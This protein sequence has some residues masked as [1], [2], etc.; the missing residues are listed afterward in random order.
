MPIVALA[1]MAVLAVAVLPSSLRPPPDQANAS[2]ELSPDAPPEDSPDA[3]ISSFT[4]A[5]SSTA[6]AGSDDAAPTTTLPPPEPERRASTGLCFGDPPRQTESV[7]APECKPEFVGDNGGATAK[8]VFPDQVN[9][10][11]WHGATVPENKGPVPTEPGSNEN[12][13]DRTLR[14]LQAYFNARYETYNRRIQLVFIDTPDTTDTGQQ[15]AAATAD[16]TYQVFASTHL[17]RAY[18]DELVRRGVICYSENP[19]PDRDLD[20]A[21]PYFWS[22]Q[23]SGTRN[24]RLVAEYLCKRLVGGTAD[25][26]AGSQQGA[27]RKFG[28]I[29]E[30]DTTGRSFEDF[31]RAF[32][33]ACGETA[34]GYDVND[35]SRSGEN[36]GQ[37]AVAIASLQSKGVTTIVNYMQVGSQLVAMQAADSAGYYPEWFITGSYGSDFNLLSKVQPKGQMSQAFGLSGIELPRPRPEMECTRAYKTIDPNNNPDDG[38]CDQYWELLSQVVGGIQEA[39]P[40]L[41]AETFRDGFYRYGRRYPPERWAFHGGYAPG[42]HSFIDKMGEIWW[43]PDAFERGSRV[44]G[45]FTWT[46]D[47]ARYGLGEIPAGPPTELFRAGITSAPPS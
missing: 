18:C 12:A 15:A 20:A 42:D 14:V 39:G 21:S 28:V 32:Q 6:G 31:N 4:Q 16:E 29:Y 11:F 45:A 22:F 23:M 25:Y 35:P 46:H 41:T 43:D 5:G 7:Y 13:V 8:N 26:A 36:A 9:I 19:F 34:E 27:P 3:I 33:D 38:V 24:E 17:G 10:G 1:V 2:A 37:T 30:S 40:N 44:P 47:G